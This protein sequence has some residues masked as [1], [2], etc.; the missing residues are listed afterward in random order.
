VV[1]AFFL[2]YLQTRTLKIF[3]YYRI[4]F[5]IVVLLLAFLPLGFAR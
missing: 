2:Q 1:I 5:G 3:I 4:L